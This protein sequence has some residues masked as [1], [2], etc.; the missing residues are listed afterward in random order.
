MDSVRLRLQ[1]RVLVDAVEMVQSIWKS[2]MAWS[3]WIL[4]KGNILRLVFF[5]RYVFPA[6]IGST[7]VAKGGRL[8]KMISKFCFGLKE[9]QTGCKE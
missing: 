8:C 2:C 6:K 1:I 5:S 3:F 7:R 9:V 4:V